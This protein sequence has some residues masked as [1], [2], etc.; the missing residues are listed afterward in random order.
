M[1]AKA[2]DHIVLKGNKVGHADRECEVLEVRGD[3]GGSP[4][5]VRWSDGHEALLY[6]GT[7]ARVVNVKSA[8]GPRPR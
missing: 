7:D 8:R 4:Y 5:F 3:D 1:R 6:P 2:G